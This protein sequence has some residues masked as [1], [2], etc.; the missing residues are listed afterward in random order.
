MSDQ[1]KFLRD[2]CPYIN[3]HRGKTFV[4]ALGGETVDHANFNHIVQDI[5][6]LS[7][8]GIRLVLVHGAR[9]QIDQR[10]EAVGL[11]ARYHN[12]RRITD[13]ATMDCVRQAVGSTRIG[14]EA[15][16]STDALNTPMRGAKIKVVSGNF[17]IARPLGVHDG[18][19]F[20]HTGKVRRVDEKGIQSQLDAGATVL[21][22][23]VGYSPTG[24]AFNLNFE[25]VATQVA[26]ALD[27]EKLI[28]F[29]SQAGVT[30]G[31]GSLVKTISLP[32]VASWLSELSADNPLYYTLKACHKAC[33]KGV[34]RGHIISYR[35][36]GALLTELF[37]R[38][39]GGTMVLEDS[40]VTMREA[41]IDDIGGLLDII[42]P[43][44]KQGVLVRRSRKLL[45]NEISRFV[46]AQHFEG[47]IIGC[48]AIYPFTDTEGT[49]SAELACVATHRDFQG[50]GLAGKLLAHM[51]LK[52]VEQDIRHLFVLTTQA[53]DWF[54]ENGFSEATLEAL[55][56]EKRQLYNY[57]RNSKILCKQL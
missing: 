13:A 35:Q 10:L 25:E 45:E 32:E 38:D 30:N 34:A 42:I 11:P 43:L 27:A 33:K 16:L 26:I 36:D 51:E 39:G 22:S 19:D 7:S 18:I 12:N 24:V 56:E 8:L 9:P 41:T 57:R 29:C 2:T 5:A 3:A 21:I 15:Q 54:K 55:P 46:V 4:L 1:V 31:A 23:P 49:T 17:V 14:I 20:H 40:M 53:A 37:T 50:Q 44:E 28:V 48:A 47:N 6:L 52:A